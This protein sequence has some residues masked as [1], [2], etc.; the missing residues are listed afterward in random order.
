MMNIK[1]A[2]PNSTVYRRLRWKLSDF[3]YELQ[4]RM[5]RTDQDKHAFVRFAE[6]APKT[7]SIIRKYLK[8]NV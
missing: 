2:A 8:K 1:R 7:L 3:P 6:Y 5:V 4:M